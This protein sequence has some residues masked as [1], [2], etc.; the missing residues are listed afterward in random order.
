MSMVLKIITKIGKILWLIIG[1]FIALWIG[2]LVYKLHLVTNPGSSLL[3]IFLLM[4]SLVI[5]VI[6]IAITIAA[7]IIKFSFKIKKK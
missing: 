3:L 2:Y 5:A 7:K 1:G 6:Y 4:F